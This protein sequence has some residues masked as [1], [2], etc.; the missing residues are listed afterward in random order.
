GARWGGSWG[1]LRGLRRTGEGRGRREEGEARGCRRCT[2]RLRTGTGGWR[3]GCW[4]RGPTGASGGHPRQ[5]APRERGATRLS[6]PSSAHPRAPSPPPPLPPP[7]SAPP[8][9]PLHQRP[10]APPPPTRLTRSPPPTRSPK[11]AR[12]DEGRGWR[13]AEGSLGGRRGRSCWRRRSRW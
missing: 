12:S 10:S 4:T 9:P 8:P 5:A 1:G 13:G 2:L 6:T 3:R 11:R 7:P